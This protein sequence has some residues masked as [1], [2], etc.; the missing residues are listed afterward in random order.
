MTLQIKIFMAIKRNDIV[1]AL[2]AKLE[3]ST[4]CIRGAR[5]TSKYC[6]GTL[7]QG[8]KPPN[9]LRGMFGGAYSPHPQYMCSFVFS[10]LQVFVK[11]KKGFKN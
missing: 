10:K 9:A 6:Q 5:T 3:K 8:T 11:E 1:L 7:E 2:K 4:G